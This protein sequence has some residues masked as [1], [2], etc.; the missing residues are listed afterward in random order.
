[1][2]LL[3]AIGVSKAWLKAW[4]E[5]WAEACAEAWGKAEARAGANIV[6]AAFLRGD[7]LRT[8]SLCLPSGL[9]SC[10]TPTGRCHVANGI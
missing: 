7:L 3:C 5:A 2:T 6:V 10:P 4:A 9:A 8:S 1:M